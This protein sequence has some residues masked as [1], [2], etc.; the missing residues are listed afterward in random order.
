MVLGVAV[1]AEPDRLSHGGI[2]GLFDLEVGGGGVEE[3]QSTSGFNRSTVAQKTASANGSSTS[4]SQS[5]AQ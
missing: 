5:M 3:Q 2:V 4:N 1:G